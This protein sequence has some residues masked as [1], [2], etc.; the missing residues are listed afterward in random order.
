MR[1]R[2]FDGIYSIAEK[3]K[4][5]NP[6]NNLIIGAGLLFPKQILPFDL[7]FLTMAQLAFNEGIAKTRAVKSYFIREAP[8]KGS[9]AI[10]GGIS[11]FLNT[12]AN[13][14]FQ[15]PEVVRELIQY[16]LSKDF[17]E[18]LYNGKRLDVVIHSIPEGTAFF[19]NEPA[20]VVEGQLAHVHLIEGVLTECVNPATLFL[21]KWHRME[22]A[23]YPSRVM[24][25]SRRRAQNSQ[26][27]S[28]YAML[29]GCD[30]TSNCD[31]SRAFNFRTAGSM[32]HEAV[33]ARGGTKETAEALL[34]H[35]PYNPIMLV[36]TVDCLRVDFP[37]WL[38]A[39]E[40]NMEA[41]KDTGSSYW[42]WRNDSGDLAE[43]TLKQLEMVRNSNISIDPWFTSHMRI[44]ISNELDENTVR[45]IKSQLYEGFKKFGW[46]PELVFGVGTNAGV[47]KDQPA[48]GGVCKLVDINGQPTMKQSRDDS[49]GISIKASIPGFNFSYDIFSDDVLECIAILSYA[50]FKPIIHNPGR[51]ANANQREVEY[52][53]LHHFTDSNFMVRVVNYKAY[54]RQKQIFLSNSQGVNIAPDAKQLTAEHVLKNIRRSVWE[55][56]KAMRRLD[57]P[58][59]MKVLVSQDILY[60]KNAMVTNSSVIFP[61]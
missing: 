31:L 49:G 61:S 18:Y 41:I 56:P 38:K 32:G 12:L 26:R 33:Q 59:R 7:Y 20:V 5:P 13:I 58:Q 22:I 57:N 45:S 39:V 28:L 3:A 30:A 10:L 2:D 15:D 46:V 34:A 35:N 9:Y 21:T 37:A 55:L 23:A 27:A 53:Q 8:F 54:K 16:N 14:N 44:V 43:L 51:L 42:G 47:C 50:D 6:E 29:A 36:D 11:E 48:L 17:I 19:P 25:M 52:L 4:H 60:W 40:A 24:D 1:S